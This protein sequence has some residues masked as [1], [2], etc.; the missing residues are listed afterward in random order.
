MLVCWSSFI[1]VNCKSTPTHKA[2]QTTI[3]NYPPHQS[4]QWKSRLAIGSRCG[5][6]WPVRRSYWDIKRAWTDRGPRLEGAAAEKRNIRCS[7]PSLYT[8]KDC[9]AIQFAGIVYWAC[10][11]WCF[12]SRK[13]VRKV[14]GL[15]YVFGDWG[16]EL[17][18]QLMIPDLSVAC[19]DTFLMP[20]KF[21]EEILSI[22]YFVQILKVINSRFFLHRKWKTELFLNKTILNLLTQLLNVQ[23]YKL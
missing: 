11:K 14:V 10:F 16:L 12:N 1:C 9:R 7:L 5:P 2:W 23:F 18:A 3:L 4:R 6:S 20:T 17:F 13:D 22:Y 8:R 15:I 19:F 21:F